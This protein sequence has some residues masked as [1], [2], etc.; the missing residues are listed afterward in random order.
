MNTHTRVT[1]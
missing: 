1:S